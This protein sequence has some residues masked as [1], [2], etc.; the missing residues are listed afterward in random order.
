MMTN[1]IWLQRGPS[2]SQISSDEYVVE[3]EY[4]PLKSYS[5][6]MIWGSLWFY[7]VC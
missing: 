2:Q 7:R 6:L 1:L 5:I 4:L 3:H